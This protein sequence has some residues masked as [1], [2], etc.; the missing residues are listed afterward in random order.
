MPDIVAT[1]SGEASNSYVTL[2]E[3]EGY[4][5]GRLHAS[6]WETALTADKEKALVTACR[7]I[8]SCRLRVNRRVLADLL[9][10]VVAT[11]AL[12]FPRCRDVDARGAYIIPEPVRLAQFEEALGLL[13][14]GAEQQRRGALQAGGVQQFSVDGLSETFSDKARTASP[15]TS[16]QARQLLAPFIERTGMIATSN[17]PLGE[18]TPGSG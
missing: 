8:E 1:I 12:T 5:A 7:T 13:A 4:F 14:F 15:L 2:A 18:F 11:Q 17:N 9:S 3:A 16:S 6:A 10:P